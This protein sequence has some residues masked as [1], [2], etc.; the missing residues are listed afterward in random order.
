M[1]KQRELSDCA[2]LFE[3]MQHQDV[4]PYVRQKTRYFDE[5]LFTTKQAIEEEER[6]EIVS[7]TILDEFDQP[8][9]TIS[10]LDIEGQYGFLGTWLGKPYHGKGYN[11][12]AK[13]T[14]FSELFFELGY[15]S[16]FMKIRKSNIR[17]QKAAEKLPYA[18]CA[19]ELRPALLEQLN[20]G[21]T[22]FTLY[23]VSKSSFHMYIHG[24]ELET[25]YDHQQLE[26]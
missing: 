12:L 4:Y 20:A 13:E 22:Q 10:L 24:R 1:L 21:E 5:F 17:S 8:I 11:H 25:L 16:V 19:D 2:D 23:E 18:F 6:G 14:F 3:L 9:G 7:R 26:A 15:E